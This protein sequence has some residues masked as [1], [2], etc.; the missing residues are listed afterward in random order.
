MNKRKSYEG[1]NL[2]ESVEVNGTL[3]TQDYNSDIELKQK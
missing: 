2:T 1:F 3:K